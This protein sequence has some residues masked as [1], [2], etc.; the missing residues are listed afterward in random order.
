MNGWINETQ[1]FGTR[2]YMHFKVS[3]GTV[4]L[5]YGFVTV[6]ESAGIAHSACNYRKIC[7]TIE[8]DTREAICC[9]KQI[10]SG[11]GLSCCGGEAFN[12]AVATCCKVKHGDRFQDAID[13][14][15]YLC[16]GTND[17][18]L[19]K[20]SNSSLCCGAVQYD[21]ETQ[22]CC[23]GEHLEIQ[24]KTQSNCCEEVSGV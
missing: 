17:A 10:H 8:Y 24:N 22:C 9:D 6:S 4:W 19:R 12:P 23:N 14:D 7:E 1:G 13:V 11:A 3:V 21:S 18:I 20:T 16:C 2:L 5:I 15:V